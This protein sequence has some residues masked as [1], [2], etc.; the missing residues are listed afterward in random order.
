M[1][2]KPVNITIPVEIPSLQ[3]LRGLHE[4]KRRRLLWEFMWEIR[5]A[6]LRDPRG[7]RMPTVAK[8]IKSK[9][10][11]LSHRRRL[12]SKASLEGGAE[13]AI[14]ALAKLNFISLGEYS[15]K[16]RP[17]EGEGKPRTD[18]QINYL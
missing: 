18:I 13:I 15:I 3:R 7:L 14:E 5:G 8:T 1:K 6:I 11:I 4:T 16:E 2:R 10:H 17:V 9:V 12:L